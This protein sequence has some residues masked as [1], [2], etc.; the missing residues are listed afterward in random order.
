MITGRSSYYHVTLM[1]K[2]HN[3]HKVLFP[4]KFFFKETALFVYYDLLYV[5][6]ITGQVFSQYCFITIG[7]YQNMAKSPSTES[8][9]YKVNLLMTDTCNNMDISNPN[10]DIYTCV[11][12][13][14]HDYCEPTK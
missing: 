5:K 8:V 9:C 4:Q 13:L 2:A 3:I 10:N 7:K 12:D 11:N 1:T 14:L 6:T